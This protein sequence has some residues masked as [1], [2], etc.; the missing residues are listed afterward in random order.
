MLKFDQEPVTGGGGNYIKISDGESV[1]GVLRGEVKTAYILWGDDKVKQVVDRGTP[2]AR[3]T[4]TVNMVVF[5]AKGNLEA[6]LLEHGAKM[7]KELKALSEEYDL[8]NTVIKIK[9]TGST[10]N[11]TVY[12]IMPLAKAMQPATI[13]KLEALELLPLDGALKDKSSDDTGEVAF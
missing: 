10:M 7:Y 13:A 5:D 6:K 8:E 11:N 1:T 3:F 9:R 12:S 4:F 2:G